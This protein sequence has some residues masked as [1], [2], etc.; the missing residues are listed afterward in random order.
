[1]AIVSAVAYMSYL[2]KLKT[3]V[4]KYSMLRN[5]RYGGNSDSF[6]HQIYDNYLGFCLAG[7]VALIV[8]GG[9]VILYAIAIKQKLLIRVAGVAALIAAVLFA[10]GGAIYQQKMNDYGSYVTLKNVYTADSALWIT[11]TAISVFVF[12]EIFQELR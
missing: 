8:S 4:D 5:I 2:S 12:V 3:S 9:S 1:M 7:T 10:I 6:I 11:L